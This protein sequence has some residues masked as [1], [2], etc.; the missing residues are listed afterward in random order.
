VFVR[1]AVQVRHLVTFSGPAQ[2][3]PRSTV[4]NQYFLQLVG[5]GHEPRGGAAASA[6]PTAEGRFEFR[7]S[8]PERARCAA[9]VERTRTVPRAV[10]GSVDSGKFACVAP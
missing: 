1:A 9:N 8:D 2:Q 5:R 10:L 3:Y 4:V 7:G 6:T